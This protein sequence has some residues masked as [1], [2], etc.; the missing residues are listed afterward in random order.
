MTERLYYE[1]AYLWEFDARVERIRAGKKPGTWEA[2]LDRSAFYPTGTTAIRK[3]MDLARDQFG[4]ETMIGDTMG[5]NKRMIRVFEKL[6]FKMIEK[7]PEAFVFPDGQHE[8]RL[9]FQK[10]LREASK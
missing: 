6:G 10:N 7:V 1:N 5:S 9:V 2:A 3:L 8:D 4:M